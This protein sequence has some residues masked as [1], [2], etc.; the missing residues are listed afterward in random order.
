[1]IYYILFQEKDTR[2][3]NKFKTLTDHVYEYIAEE[4]L[5]GNIELGE[6]INEN[7]ICSLLS[8]SRTPVREALIEL[9]RDGILDNVPRKGF[10]VRKLTLKDLKELYA[11]IGILESEAARLACPNLDK[12]SLDDMKFYID[13]MD[14]AISQ[15]NFSIYHKQQDAF[16]NTFVN[17]CGNDTLILT[18]A[19]L[20]NQLL[21]KTYDETTFPNIIN[22]LFDTNKEHKEIYELFKQKDAEAVGEYLKNVHWQPQKAEYEIS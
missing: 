10:V 11:L 17:K 5:S 18:L 3:M 12:K 19:H 13:S 2:R 8:I 1:M 15:S 9:S 6:K 14:L 21:R 7:Q 22:I 4:I 20:K 16:H